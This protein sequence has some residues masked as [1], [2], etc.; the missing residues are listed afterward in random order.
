MYRN[1]TPASRKLLT[2]TKKPTVTFAE[3]PVFFKQLVLYVDLKV[4]S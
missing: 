4:S 1:S 3:P 2:P